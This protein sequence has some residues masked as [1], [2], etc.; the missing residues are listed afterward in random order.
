ML[1]EIQLEEIREHLNNS[2]NPVFFY[3]NDADGL[4]SYVLL[5]K[6]LGRGKGVAIRTH[7]DIDVNYIR[8][9]Q[10]FNADCV[11]VLDK[12]ILGNAFVTEIGKMG[13]PIVWIDHHNA[14]KNYENVSVY[15]SEIGRAHV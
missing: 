14:S 1:T 12:P 13:I 3:D 15:D 2:Q 8:K 11:F 6:Y 5:R 9:V 10:E 4:C 7:P